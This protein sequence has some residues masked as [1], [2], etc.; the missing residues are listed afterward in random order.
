MDRKELKSAEIRN[1]KS[2]LVSTKLL[3][4]TLLM[5]AKAEGLS[6]AG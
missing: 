2:G 5:R 1:K 3:Q 6:Y 4:V